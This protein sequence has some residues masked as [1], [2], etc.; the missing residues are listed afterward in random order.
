MGKTTFEEIWDEYLGLES[1][2]KPQ[3]LYDA[4]ITLLEQGNETAHRA[5]LF[6]AIED[7]FAV[8][9]SQTAANATVELSKHLV[10]IKEHV[11]ATSVLM[12]S[13]VR[14]APW[15]S[16][17]LGL[18]YR[19]LAWSYRALGDT[20]R[21]EEC[22]KIAI[23]QLDSSSQFAWSYPSK[24]ELG[25]VLLLRGEWSALA[26]LVSVVTEETEQ[27]VAPIAKS[28]RRYLV[29]R[30]A[31][32]QLNSDVAIRELLNSVLILE[33]EHHRLLADAFDS[34]GWA[35]QQRGKEVAEVL[36][37]FESE[38][39]IQ[40]DVRARLLKGLVADS[41]LFPHSI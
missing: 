34:L 30:V 2:E 15:Q 19:S 27:S 3:F 31:L 13:I 11:E 37:T 1:V 28:V 8:G 25:E 12:G 6:Q 9:D 35:I 36:D 39:G 10:D 41:R 17:E 38:L 29:G 33:R 7:A 20:L 32:H 14:F 26:D 24:N 23:A 16:F 5:I 18:S 22:L 40:P 4:S 21:H